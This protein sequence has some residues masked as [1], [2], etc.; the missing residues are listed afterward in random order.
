MDFAKARGDDEEIS[1]D[2]LADVIPQEGAPGLRRRPAPRNQ[3]F[4]DGGLTN[5]DP[6]FQQSP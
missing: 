5:I 2:D 1:R 4:R 6:E 3:V